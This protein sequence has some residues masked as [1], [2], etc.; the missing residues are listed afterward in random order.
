MAKGYWVVH[1]DVTEPVGYKDYMQA[2]ME[3][4]GRYGGRFL[5]R[6]GKLELEE[7]KTRSRAV[8]IEFPT[9]EAALACYKS[10]GYQ[11]AAAL[12]KGK[13]EFDLIVV[14]G[15]DGPQPQ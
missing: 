8:V 4:I 12:R 5:V 6:G 7:G 3:P 15:Y 9:Y 10:P 11:A 2:D 13:A 1:A 14:E